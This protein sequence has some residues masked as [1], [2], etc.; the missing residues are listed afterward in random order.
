M[1]SFLAR[2]AQANC[3]FPS[4]GSFVDQKVDTVSWL[5][6]TC[7]L[8]LVGEENW[9]NA[10]LLLVGYFF[11]FKCMLYHFVDCFELLKCQEYHSK[12]M[13]IP[14]CYDIL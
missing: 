1:T 5:H 2:I 6:W 14:A 13:M 9:L 11:C 10:S 8:L 7:V 12:A 4:L 3:S